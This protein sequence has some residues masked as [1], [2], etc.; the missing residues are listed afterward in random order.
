MSNINISSGLVFKKTF[1]SQSL[2]TTPSVA[3]NGRIISKTIFKNQNIP[4]L[5][6]DS[7]Y[8]APH[9]LPDSFEVYEIVYGNFSDNNVQSISDYDLQSVNLNNSSNAVEQRILRSYV[10]DIMTNRDILKPVIDPYS[11]NPPPQCSI[12]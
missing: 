10:K 12:P 1:G 9:G 4:V 2:N 3:H 8:Y 5:L 11:T 6:E 7:Q